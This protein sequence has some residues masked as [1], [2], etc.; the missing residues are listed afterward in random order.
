MKLKTIP[1]FVAKYLILGCICLVIPALFSSAA[2]INEKNE[3]ALK[4]KAIYTATVF[5]LYGILSLDSL[6]LSKEAFSE[7]ITAIPS[8]IHRSVIETIKNGSCFFIYGKNKRY[9]G[10]SKLLKEPRLS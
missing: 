7:A 6:G 2:I 8:G 10:Q 4:I 5:D 1:P 9:T 3:A